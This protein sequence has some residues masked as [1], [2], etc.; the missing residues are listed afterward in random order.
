MYERV[1]RD[2]RESGNVGGGVNCMNAI[3]QQQKPSVA[4]FCNISENYY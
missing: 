4:G 3:R 1:Y 2:I